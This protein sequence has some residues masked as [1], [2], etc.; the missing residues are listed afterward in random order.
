MGHLMHSTEAKALDRE[1]PQ[2]ARDAAALAKAEHEV[3]TVRTSHR[4]VVGDARELDFIPEGSVHLV[5]TSPPYWNLKEY[6]D[7]ED[8]MGHIDDYEKFLN[9]LDKVWRGCYRALAEGGRM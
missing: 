8:Q 4:L 2:I 1:I 7:H 6:E 3:R 9:E 5:V